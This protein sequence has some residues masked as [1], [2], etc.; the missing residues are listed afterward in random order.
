MMLR[1]AIFI[2]SQLY[3]RDLKKKEA[4]LTFAGESG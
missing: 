1:R 3:I 2:N 4:T